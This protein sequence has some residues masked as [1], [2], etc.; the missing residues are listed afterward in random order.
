MLFYPWRE[1]SVSCEAAFCMHRREATEVHA[2][3]TL[4]KAGKDVYIT[5]NTPLDQK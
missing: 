3:G 2:V 4:C 1:L 5:T